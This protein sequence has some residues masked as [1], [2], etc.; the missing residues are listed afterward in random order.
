[1]TAVTPRKISPMASGPVSPTLRRAYRE[2]KPFQ[3]VR[4]AR[5]NSDEAGATKCVFDVDMASYE[6]LG[7]L[8]LQIEDNGKGID[9]DDVAKF[10][11][12][13]GG[14]G[15]PIGDEHDNFGVGFKS[16]ALPWNCD[17][18]VIRSL[19]DGE[20]NISLLVLDPDTGEVGLVHLPL[21]DE[22]NVDEDTEYDTTLVFDVAT[23]YAVGETWI[24]NDIDWLQSFPEWIVAEGHGTV[25]TFLGTASNPD[26]FFGDPNVTEEQSSR[27][28]YLWY[29]DQRFWKI[30]TGV[31][32]SIGGSDSLDRKRITASLDKRLKRPVAATVKHWEFRRVRGLHDCIYMVPKKAGLPPDT[33]EYEDIA[34]VTTHGWIK[35]A[36][37]DIG[38]DNLPATCTVYFKDI[39][40]IDPN[41]DIGWN[42]ARYGVVAAL[43][44]NENYDIDS[45]YR[46]R[47][48][49]IPYAA[50]YHKTWIIIEPQLAGEDESGVYPGTSRSQLHWK[51]AGS[52]GNQL[53]WIAW[54]DEFVARM[55]AEV[56]FLDA[57][58]RGYISAAQSEDD[59]SKSLLKRVANRFLTRFKP[60]PKRPKLTATTR[61]TQQAGS[62]QKKDEDDEAEDAGTNPGASGG[63]RGKGK[64]KRKPSPGPNPGPSPGDNDGDSSGDQKLVANK[65]GPLHLIKRGQDNDDLP[66]PIWIDFTSVYPDR[67]AEAG[68][69]DLG[70]IYVD[71]APAVHCNIKH[72]VIQEVIEFWVADFGEVHRAS[73]TEGVKDV[74]GMDVSM[75]VGH[76]VRQRLDPDTLKHRLDDLTNKWYG[77]WDL[78]ELVGKRVRDRIGRPVP[79]RRTAS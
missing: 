28:A 44:K 2:G 76:I 15:K 42:P 35:T 59:I 54:A 52:R 3:W 9:P 77:V 33:D 5:V 68:K 45:G 25:F 22:D 14:G 65:K 66:P 10:L 62:L 72:P 27:W 75:A 38:A 30:P 20:I 23:E 37:F 49:G 60:L 31:E 69:A 29:A 32:F 24:Y 71:S 12:T 18:I 50:I 64:R 57:A 78:H 7:V 19:V 41:R 11:N 26:T 34:S 55:A 56:P 40:G 61:N 79:R 63:V 1:M 47:Q 67:L 70:A 8:R 46:H 13:F 16:A 51:G 39:P 53:P 73:V 6:K 17:G 74:Y 48:F 4:E 43:Y 58:I 36:T 21:D